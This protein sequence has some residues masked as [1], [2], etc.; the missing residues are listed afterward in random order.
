MRR[1]HESKTSRGGYTLVE[2]MMVV[3]IIA[4]STLAFSPGISRAVADRRV[5]SAARELIRI[6]RRARADSFGYLRAHLV[7]IT[8]ATGRVMLLRG[9]NNSCL[10]PDWNAISADCPGTA[11]GVRGQRCL[12]QVFISAI[13]GPSAMAMREELVSSAGVASY[14]TTARALCYAPSGVVYHGTGTTL[15]VAAAAATLSE[16][17][18]ATI[19]GGFVY[20]LHTGTVDPVSTDRVHRVLFPLGS[21][22]RSLR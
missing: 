8:P 6:G 4:A 11:T 14:A 16:A 20:T 3:A 7:W 9:T 1:V 18:S 5:S 19:K 2:L 10:L 13:A 21:S 15:G 22:A 12:E 17:N